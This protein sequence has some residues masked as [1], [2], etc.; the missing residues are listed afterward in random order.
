MSF[1]KRAR[2]EEGVWGIDSPPPNVS[3]SRSDQKNSTQGVKCYL[4]G[5]LLRIQFGL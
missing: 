4:T 2:S 5:K 3:I 1:F